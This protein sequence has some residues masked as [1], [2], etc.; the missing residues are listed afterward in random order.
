MSFLRIT[1]FLFL[2]A[3]VFPGQGYASIASAAQLAAHST[4]PITFTRTVSADKS[5]PGDPVRAKTMQAV[6][7]ADG[8]QVP[9][10]T[11]VIGHVLTARPFRYDKTPYAKQLAGTLD[12][13]IDALEVQGGQ[14]PL[15]VSLRA[16]ADPL[17]SWQATEPKSTDLDSLGTTTQIG[18]DLLVPSQSEIRD[19]SGDVVGYNKK[20]GAFA[21]LLANSRGSLTCDAGDSEQPVSIFSASACGLYGFTGMS[22]MQGAPSH[23]ALSSTHSS[24]RIWKQSTALL[25]AIPA[26]D[27]NRQ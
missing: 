15:S 12:I 4:L 5:R 8:R 1:T 26:A 21:H 25:E 3:S 24:P 27:A 19:Q 9:A 18:G 11:L 2:T 17:T 7:L 23:I 22:L 13:Q 10:G 6:R 16:M 20:G 14:L